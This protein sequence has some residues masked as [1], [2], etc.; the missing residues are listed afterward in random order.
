MSSTPTTTP[1]TPTGARWRTGGHR[2][3]DQTLIEGF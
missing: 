1:T 2:A 3:V